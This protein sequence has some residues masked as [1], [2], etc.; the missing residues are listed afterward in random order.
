MPIRSEF[1]LL[2]AL[3]L[4]MCYFTYV[5]F[6]S[7]RASPA[8]VTEMWQPSPV[9]TNRSGPPDIDEQ[10]ETEPYASHYASDHHY[11]VPMEPTCASPPQPQPTPPPCAD[12]LD[13]APG[14]LQDL[15]DFSD[16]LVT[17]EQREELQV[18]TDNAEQIQSVNERFDAA[19]RKVAEHGLR[20]GMKTNAERR[21]MIDNMLRRPACS[22][23]VRS[24]RT[25]NSDTLRGDAVPKHTSSSWGMIRARGSNPN[26]DLHP[27]SM[28]FLSG[29]GGKWLSEETV[30]D[31]AVTDPL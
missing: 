5:L 22:R 1:M 25:E 8:P 12:E 21:R 31:N 10:V 18:A 14:T 4:A 20:P 30:P 23:R 6:L 29:L 7:K 19:K 15:I 13:E 3:F 28:G 16:C 17:E 11:R 27:G 24:W 2:V 9:A 26:V